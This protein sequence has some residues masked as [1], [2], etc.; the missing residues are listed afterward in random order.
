MN[1]WRFFTAAFLVIATGIMYCDGNV[2][3]KILQ[4]T[5][6]CTGIINEMEITDIEMF[7]PTEKEAR[8]NFKTLGD[9]FE[10][11]SIIEEVARNK[12]WSDNPDLKAQEAKIL[13][14]NDLFKLS[15]THIQ[16]VLNKN[17]E[18][19]I[20][21]VNLYYIDVTNPKSPLYG[22]NM[23]V[24]M[25]LLEKMRAKTHFQKREGMRLRFSKLIAPEGEMPNSNK[26]SFVDAK[27]RSCYCMC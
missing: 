24:L 17:Q 16:A 2:Q 14:V 26:L 18:L 8:K 20:T 5:M 23:T 9:T 12:K 27:G 10:I 13:A 3:S 1:Y 21:V 25:G 11:M 22:Q 7:V 6:G 19:L 4:L 15:K